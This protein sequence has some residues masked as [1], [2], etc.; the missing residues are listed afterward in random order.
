MGASLSLGW[1]FGVFGAL[2]GLVGHGPGEQIL[3]SGST[4]GGRS[5]CE[6]SNCTGA[7]PQPKSGGGAGGFGMGGNPF[8]V[9]ESM[10][11]LTPT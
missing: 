5:M 8:D 6:S 3:S 1:L 2:G 9:F 4:V 10:F 7:E 11:G